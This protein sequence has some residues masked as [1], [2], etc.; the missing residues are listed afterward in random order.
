MILLLNLLFSQSVVFERLRGFSAISPRGKDIVK[1]KL[2]W[3]DILHYMDSMRL[4][5]M[6]WKA[7]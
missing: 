1:P 3:K 5:S 7:V 4:I 6:I 2:T